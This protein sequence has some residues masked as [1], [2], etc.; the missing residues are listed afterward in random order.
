MALTAFAGSPAATGSSGVRRGGRIALLLLI[1]GIAYLL[2]FFLAPLISLVMTSL[3]SPSETVFGQYDFTFNWANYLQVVGQY[4]EQILRS[5]LYAVLATVFALLF[6]YPL[7]YFIGV[8]MRRWPL[9]QSLLL[10]LVVAPLFISFLLR[11]LAWKQILSDEGFVVTTLKALSLL[12]PQD[13]ITGTGIAV[14]FGLTYNFIPFMC[15]PLYTT[16]ERLDLRVVEASRDLYATPFT[17]FRT[18]ILPL[19]MPGIVSGTLL[20]FIPAAG[21][22]VNASSQFLGGTSSTM[23]GNVI[24]S[25]FL[26]QLNYPAA[27]ALSILLMATILVLVGFYVR[28][29]G[30]E[31]LL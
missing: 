30:T 16:L 17:T 29:S 19:S 7:A 3:Q 6:S 10:I 21:D 4:S 28:R 9:V 25:N 18:V 11:T 12:G 8:T 22:Y 27:A 5:F 23:I 14:V 15:L 1:P 26:V 2:L 31:D 13:H 24:Q 20:T